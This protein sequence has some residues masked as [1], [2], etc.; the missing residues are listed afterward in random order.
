MSEVLGSEVPRI[1]T[2]PLRPL[3]PE[4]SLGFSAIEFAEDVLLLPLLPWQ[5]WLLVHALEVLEDGSFRFDK[6]IVSVARQ[7]GKTVLSQ[8][9]SLW[10]VYVL[11]KRTV[12]GTAQD[13]D[14]AEEAWQNAVDLIQETDD[15]DQP[16]RPDLLDLLDRVVQVNGK[17]ALVLKTGERYKVKA[18]NRKAG[19]G[20]SG[21]V[22]IL[23]EL[24][25]HQTWD[26]WA[27]ITHTT[28]ARK[29]SQVWCFS[30]AGDD[31]SVV[32]RYFRLIA[33]RELGDPDGIVAKE[34][35]AAAPTEWDAEQAGEALEDDVE[36]EEL[37]VDAADLGWFEWSARPGATKLDV[38]GIRYAN[39]S[40]G[41]GFLTMRK[42]K[43]A[44][45]EPDYIFR[46]EVL[47]QWVEGTVGGLLDMDEWRAR[48]ND[49][50]VLPSGARR[51]RERDRITSKLWVGIDLAQD[52]SRS[53]IAVFGQSQDGRW[54]G[55]LAASGLGTDWIA[56][57]LLERRGRIAAI[58]GQSSGAPVSEFLTDLGKGNPF[59][60][61]LIAPWAR[62]DLVGGHAQFFD[63]VRDGLFWHSEQPALDRAAQQAVPKVL[64]GGKLVDR[65]RSD[66]DVSPLVALIAAWWV[67][68]RPRQRKSAPP[69]MAKVD[70]RPVTTNNVLTR[71]L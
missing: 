33:H 35:L 29:D 25:E 20:L 63:A 49:P 21:D 23:D 64:P 66:V 43:A 19:R 38:E 7:N 68:Q 69:P 32:F 55:T 37:Q 28:M 53:Y 40:L 54:Q 47:C 4:T 3:T 16:V 45:L 30:N 36:L 34:E 52:R 10:S 5:K 14:T 62:D 65:M 46:T 22:V 9:I 8:V 6:V 41:Y 50:L 57:W 1:W 59:L 58:A 11:G 17:K 67:S 60:S 39:P 24:R 71:P 2:P 51:P 26:A 15:N 48:Y 61:G 13:L 42:V 31:K 56:E 12:L 44:A 70:Y 27:A 18:A